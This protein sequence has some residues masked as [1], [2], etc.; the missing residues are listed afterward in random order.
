M[1]CE[2]NTIS[3][4]IFRNKIPYIITK[5]EL[6]SGRDKG[7]FS[8]NFN[9]GSLEGRGVWQ[10]PEFQ[11]Q[12]KNQI[13]DSGQRKKRV[14]KTI[15]KYLVLSPANDLLLGII[16]TGQ[17]LP[18]PQAESHI[19][20]CVHPVR[21]LNNRQRQAHGP[22]LRQQ[23]IKVPNPK[24]AELQLCIIC[25]SKLARFLQIDELSSSV[26][27]ALRPRRLHR[28]RPT[29]CRPAQARFHLIGRSPPHLPRPP[30]WLSGRARRVSK[31]IR[32]A[33]KLPKA[34][35]RPKDEKQPAR[36]VKSW[37]GSDVVR[38]ADGNGAIR[39]SGPSNPARG[40]GHRLFSKPVLSGNQNIQNQSE[41]KRNQNVHKQLSNRIIARFFACHNSFLLDM[42]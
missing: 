41:S 5:D 27:P 7:G 33:E 3:K 16:F 14:V 26:C 38:D 22:D 31:R 32:K 11:M 9:L 34:D 36:G 42:N 40:K 39:R 15:A 30:R 1:K 37:R 17:T 20:T 19:D 23:E 6:L 28:L 24:E 25:F 21:V 13:A 18:K 29:L 2:I 10:I 35:H 4:F 8:E 12:G